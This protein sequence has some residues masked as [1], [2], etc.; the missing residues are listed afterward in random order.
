MVDPGECVIVDQSSGR[1]FDEAF[2]QR[3]QPEGVPDC[4]SPEF[5]ARSRKSSRASLRDF[6]MVM[7]MPRS[8]TTW[9]GKVF[10]SH[11]DTLYRHEPDAL[12]YARVPRDARDWG[13]ERV[14]KF[15]DTML[16]ERSA[17]TVSKF[18]WFPKS[19][20][21]VLRGRT[22]D[23]VLVAARVV[24]QAGQF[25][26]V[27]DLIAP[28]E[29]ERVRVVWKSVSCSRLLGAIA[30][31]LPQS[32]SVAITRHP[33]GY[34]ASVVRGRRRGKFDGANDDLGA[35]DQVLGSATGRTSG[36]TRDNYAALSEVERL[37]WRW[38]AGNEQL[39]EA[40]D[41]S[42]NVRGVRYED[43][44]TAP[45][46]VG[47]ELLGFAG[48][49]WG[50]QCQGFIERSTS[51]PRSGFYSVFKDPKRA[52]MR[53]AEELTTAEV[54]AIREIADASRAGQLYLERESILI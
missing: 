7:G 42:P 37:A 54:D 36:L 14:L 44:C 19:Y 3:S 22:R 32:R 30:A 33:C 16:D 8:G 45:A 31:Q 49:D 15:V 51:N 9:L 35:V 2:S 47:R 17:R 13:R 20:Y 25:I 28:A 29:L 23:A 52:M 24:A 40:I 53:W 48:L 43:L 6:I 10:D 21:S 26:D 4:R 5:I 50:E 11:P 18:P 39:I 38:V 46:R 34:V 1:S 12:H 41:G 27:P